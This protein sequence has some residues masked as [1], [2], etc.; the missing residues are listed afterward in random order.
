LVYVLPLIIEETGL[1]RRMRMGNGSGKW[2]M[3]VGNG[4]WQWEMGNG[5][6]KWGMGV[7]NG[8]WEW[9]M[10]NGSGKWTMGNEE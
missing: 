6:G 3:A 5:S 1:E 9:E 8:E 10:G 2:G 7:G 4:E